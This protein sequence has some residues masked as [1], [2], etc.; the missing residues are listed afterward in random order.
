MIDRQIIRLI[1][2]VE[3]LSQLDHPFI[4]KFFGVF[5]NANAIYICMELCS[6]GEIISRVK[7]F[8]PY[9]EQVAAKI[10]H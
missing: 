6:G 5:N 7:E 2:E 1:S 10:M 8:G 9:N 4:V 3:I